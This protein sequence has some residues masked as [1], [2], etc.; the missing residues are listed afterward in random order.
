[1]F[2]GIDVKHKKHF[3]PSAV[4]CHLN[5][6]HLLCSRCCKIPQQ[7]FLPRMLTIKHDLESWMRSLLLLVAI[8]TSFAVSSFFQHTARLCIAFH[9]GFAGLYQS[10]RQF[11]PTLSIAFL[12]LVLAKCN[13]HFM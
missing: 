12:R 4:A 9:S 3:Q 2:E 7:L 13:Q 10:T 5:N 8:V 6:K 1:M 11:L